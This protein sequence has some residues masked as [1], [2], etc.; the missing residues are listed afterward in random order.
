M[1]SCSQHLNAFLCEIRVEP[2]QCEPGTVNGWLANFPMKPHARAFQ[3]HVQ[4]FR[5]RIVKP[6]NSD[7][8]NAFLLTA[9]GCNRL[10]PASFRH[11]LTSSVNTAQFP[12]CIA[13]SCQKAS[14]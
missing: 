13:R 7:N 9:R 11:C 4:L 6:F 1:L 3:L 5:M 10:D 8:R 12:M 14:S 2:G